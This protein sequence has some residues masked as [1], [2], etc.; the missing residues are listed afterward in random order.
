MNSPE[1]QFLIPSTS[2][3][4][5]PSWAVLPNGGE[6]CLNGTTEE[7]FVRW[8]PPV[9]SPE[10]VID[11]R[12]GKPQANLA[13]EQQS[14]PQSLPSDYVESVTPD[15]E[16]EYAHGT[17]SSQPETAQAKEIPEQWNERRTRENKAA[18][19][20]EMEAKSEDEELEREPAFPYPKIDDAAF[21]GPF[22]RIVKAIAP[23]TEADPIGVLIALLVGW[24]NLIGRSA[25]HSVGA[26]RH[27][28]NL[29]CCI[30]GRTA[31]ARKGLGLGVAGWLL[32]QL[33]SQWVDNHIWSGLSSGEGLI[34]KVRDPIIKQ[35]WVK[36][37]QGAPGHVETYIEDQGITDKRLLVA[38]T[39]F[40]STLAVMGR[41]GNT[42]SAVIRDAFDSKKRLGQLVKNSPGT[43]TG[44]HISIIGHITAFELR[45]LMKEC[46]QWNGFGNRFAFVCVK[47]SDFHSDPPDLSEAGISAEMS[48][49]AVT[50][51]WARKVCEM[52]RIEEAKVLWDKLY[53]EFAEDD[54]ETIV[55]ATIDRGD[56]FMLRFQELYALSE[57]SLTI[58][59]Q[60]VRA[61]VALWKYCENSARYLFGVRLSNPKA[62]K[63]FDA[64]R[65]NPGG[66]TRTEI[67]VM[68]FKRNLNSDRLEKAL[69]LLKKIGWIESRLEK[70]EG[71]NAERFF[72]KM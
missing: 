49:L 58:K 43:A 15:E 66:L 57:D 10:A 18:I 19:F 55:S 34:W 29:N 50:T 3:Q 38:E 53:R 40:G 35:R 62:E 16:E 17:A 4:R 51:D 6:Y 37:K 33:D 67:N 46:E 30:V 44:A 36:G 65:K 2:W 22:G 21:H 60:H 13:Q 1:P 5:V 26:D 41:S 71:R 24:G 47:R 31:R 52:D 12:T 56:V 70:T 54:A 72:A 45:N 39:E 7:K 69:A 42:L 11:R 68:V 14:A 25:Y 59:E 27:Y 9:P 64:L 48:Q 8:N 23:L 32:A 61:A 28:T 63:I 20:A